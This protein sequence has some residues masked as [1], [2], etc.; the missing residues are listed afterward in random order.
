MVGRGGGMEID[1]DHGMFGERN[2]VA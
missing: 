1:R 2:H